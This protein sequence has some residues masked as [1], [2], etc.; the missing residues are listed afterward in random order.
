[1]M[2]KVSTIGFT[3]KNAQDFFKIL[4]D[5]GIDM[6]LDIRLNN[7]SQLAAFAK[8]PD[9]EFFLKEICDIDYVHDTTFSPTELT[10]KRFKNKE[11]D[12]SQYVEEFSTTMR[13]RNIEDLI[14]KKYIVNKNI[15]LLCS[16]PTAEKCHRGLVAELFKREMNN[17]EIIHL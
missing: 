4:K 7:T 11:I 10:L 1:M 6:V 9:I 13:Q 12:W 15:C 16:E 5:N 8:Y 17:L 3:K 2:E 14:R